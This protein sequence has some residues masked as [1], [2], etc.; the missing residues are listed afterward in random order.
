MS[1]TEFADEACESFRQLQEEEEKLLCISQFDKQKKNYHLAKLLPVCLSVGGNTHCVGLL[2]KFDGIKT[3]V[4]GIAI[5]VKDMRNKANL[6]QNVH[7]DS[8]LHHSNASAYRPVSNLELFA[9][10]YS[11]H[12]Q[13][14]PQW[15]RNQLTLNDSVVFGTPL[16]IE[17]SISPLLS[18]SPLSSISPASSVSFGTPEVTP[19]PMSPITPMSIS[20][21]MPMILPIN[22]MSVQPSCPNA[23]QLQDMM[24]QMVNQIQQNI[25]ILDAQISSM[26]PNNIRN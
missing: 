10:E 16:P 2:F 11:G 6:I 21:P 22:T 12:Q 19:M 20:M 13:E 25:A 18:V 15:E 17:N 24:S 5:D 8:W 3:I 23:V 1:R 14:Q 7:F 26:Q 9:D 4:Q